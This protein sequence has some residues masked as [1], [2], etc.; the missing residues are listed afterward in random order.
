MATLA[1]PGEPQSGDLHTVR[2]L[3]TGTL[4]AAVDGLGHG[5]HAAAAAKLAAATLEAHA[6]EPLKALVQRCHRNLQ[7]TRGVV[8]SIAWLDRAEETLTW[9]GVGNVEGVLVRSTQGAAAGRKRLVADAGVVGLRLPALHP[10]TLPVAPG[11]LIIFATDGVDAAFAEA[12]IPEGPPEKVA[13]RILAAHGRNT[14]DA[15]VLV[16][17]YRG[18]A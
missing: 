15:L 17:R 6:H 8:L 10:R 1:L 3:P 18:S 9:L 7:G 2:A 12:P 13:R 16:A 11:D 14:D 5:K 4:V